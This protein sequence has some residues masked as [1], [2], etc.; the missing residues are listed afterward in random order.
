MA[1]DIQDTV[2]DV[3]TRALESATSQSNGHGRGVSKGSP[4]SGMKGLA[5]GAGAAALVPLAVKSAGKLARGAG[6]DGSAR[7]SGP[8]TKRCR[9]SAPSGATV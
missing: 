7:W 1:K 2:R 4:L 3:L 9:A 6:M 5:A 8:P